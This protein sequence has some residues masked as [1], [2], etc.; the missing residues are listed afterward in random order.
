MRELFFTFSLFCLSLNTT[1]QRL[2]LIISGNSDFESKI[3]DSLS[4]NQKHVNAKS[5]LNE[6]NLMSE[7]LTKIGYIENSVIQSTKVNDSTFNYLF[8]LKNKVDFIHIYIGKKKIFDSISNFASK[9]DTVI[10]PYLETEFFLQQIVKELEKKGF[11]LAKLKLDNLKKTNKNIIADLKIQF[12]TR[13]LI[14]DI[15][16]LGYD[17]FPKGHKNN[18]KRIYKNKTFNQ[19]NLKKIYDDFEKFRFTKQLKYPEILFEKDSTKIYVYLE[20]TKSNNFDG[21]VG[22]SNNSGT[23]IQFN[24]YLDLDLNNTLNNGERFSLFWKSD[25]NQQKT[26]NLA[27]EI[28]YLFKSPLG[29]KT[30]LNIFK[31]DSTF[32][33]T[34]TA[35]D[36]GYFFNYN[37]RTYI[38]YQSTESSDIMN[39]NSISISD[40]KNSF[41]TTQFEFINFKTDNFLFPE[42]TKIN[43]KIGLGNRKSLKNNEQ[44]FFNIDIH[45]NFYL[46]QK[47]NFY[48]KSQNYFLKSNSYLTNE[49]YRFGGIKSIRGFGENSLQANLFTSLL[50]EY[51]YTISPSLYLHS[52]IDY[53]YF[54]DRATLSSGSLTG[55]GFG[56]GLVTKNGLLNLIYA[57]GSA[58][59]FAFKGSNSIVH[60]SFKT[61]F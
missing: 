41:I 38:G 3:I 49:L 7:K 25:G 6:V 11:P 54:Q 55:I 13:R 16:I 4:Y 5:I 50:T 2:S 47:N 29:I 1:A 35:I 10:I 36:L 30:Q 18:L 51:R 42:K 61:N 43:L 8:N 21:F 9:N 59:D 58:E 60:V 53:G 20:K 14:D 24:G 45:H 26:L 15:V 27:L 12:E 57:N 28:P 40:Y 17:N 31:Q 34:K 46:N 44:S 56:F 22:F 19:D 32:Q 37:T 48:I 23:N 39:L 52:I 33:N